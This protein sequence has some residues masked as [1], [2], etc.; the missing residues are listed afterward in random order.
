MRVPI[1]GNPGP[2]AALVVRELLAAA[3]M[4]PGAPVVGDGAT[5]PR[6][7]AGRIPTCQ[8]PGDRGGS[9]KSSSSGFGGGGMGRL[10]GG[11]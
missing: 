5:G 6:G 9:E 3:A 10:G 8:S 4:D 7:G 1:V 2:L 11:R